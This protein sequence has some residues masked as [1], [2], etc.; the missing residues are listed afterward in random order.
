[1]CNMRAVWYLDE[2][3]MCNLRAVW[4]LDEGCMCNLRAVWYLDEGCMCNSPQVSYLVPDWVEGWIGLCFAAYKK[5]NP[6]IQSD[7]KCV[8]L[9]LLK[10][11]VTQVQTLNP[12][13]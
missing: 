4:Y 13:P 9:V 6:R 3:C 5:S 7:L 11:E 2:G 12:K 1:M 8:D 10:N